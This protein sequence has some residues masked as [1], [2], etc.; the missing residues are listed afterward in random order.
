MNIVFKQLPETEVA[1]IRRTGS[2]F[3]PQEHWGKLIQW[4]TEHNLYPPSSQFIGMSLDNPNFV[5]SHECR[6]DACV[7]IPENFDKAENGEI[8]FKTLE[9]GQ[10]IVHPFY[11]RPKKLKDLYEY[12]F[13]KWLPESEYAMDENRI[14][15]E[16]NLNNPAED[17][18]GK[19]K[20][21]LYVPIKNR[22]I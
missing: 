14:T 18:D 17:P 1:F 20:V 22:D 13:E 21:D 3:E 10:Y 6:H 2:Y 12:V 9:G 11:D 15:L 19:S 16:F 4:A 8:Q 7:T 5:E